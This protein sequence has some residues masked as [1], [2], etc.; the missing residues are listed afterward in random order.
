MFDDLVNDIPSTVSA[1]S[2]PATFCLEELVLVL[3]IVDNPE[4]DGFSVAVIL[5]AFFF[6]SPDF[7][8]RVKVSSP[9][10]NTLATTP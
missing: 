8:T 5:K 9:A 3:S 6:P 10:P 7:N 2:V 4:P 1:A